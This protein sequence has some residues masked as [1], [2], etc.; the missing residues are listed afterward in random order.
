MPS[1]TPR[2][3]ALSCHE[4]P[5][6]LGHAIGVTGHRRADE[7]IAHL[8]A[9]GAT[10]V[11]GPM[12]HTKP[13][14]DDGAPLRAATAAVIA[15][16]PAYLLATT[17]IGIR[18][19]IN[20]AATW[21]V[22]SE[23]LA[24]LRGTKVLARGP[25]VVGAISE[26]G[27]EV[28]FASAN[29]RTMSLIDHLSQRSLVGVHVALQLPGN[30]MDDAVERLRSAGADVTTLAIYDWTW[31]DDLAASRR[32]LR[33][34]AERRVSAVTFTSRPAVR[35]FVSLAVRDG[36]ETEIEAAFADSVLPV[37]IGSVTGDQLRALTAARACAPE[38]PMLGTMVQALADELRRRDHR[39]VRTASGREVV[40]QRRL[41]D[42]G[43]VAVVTSD[44]EAAVLQAL[45]AA[46]R[47]TVGRDTLLR[48]VW[49]AEAADPSVLETTMT[50]L[51]RRLRTTGLTVSTV[52]GRGYLLNGEEVPC[53]HPATGDDAARLQLVSSA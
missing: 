34:I 14:S 1:D 45:I 35:N 49:R 52:T 46:H 26:A 9:L 40:V 28:S 5:A 10:V 7:L 18:S 32:L 42:S 16:P 17:G 43:N 50:R 12:L 33:A 24:A 23:L 27:L 36:L 13:I 25:K 20:A 8:R 31:P 41:V 3:N 29:G 2:S 48:S 47:R 21:G 19:W 4:I 51:R 30:E 11:H 37:C 38:R 22:R 44:R 53:G 39:H 15:R 6:L